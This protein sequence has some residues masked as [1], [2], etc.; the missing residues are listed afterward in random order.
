MSMKAN[1]DALPLAVERARE[2]PRRHA[3]APSVQDRCDVRE[4]DT[5]GNGRAAYPPY[6]HGS[7]VIMASAWLAFYVIAAIHH[8]MASGN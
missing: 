7:V 5:R 2:A 4:C 1:T 3:A 6:H 8:L